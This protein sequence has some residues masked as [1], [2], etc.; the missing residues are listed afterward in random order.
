MAAN[1]F[2]V[3]SLTKCIQV[4]IDLC[5]DRSDF[6]AIALFPEDVQSEA[7]RMVF[8]PSVSVI[9]ADLTDISSN[10]IEEVINS[11]TGEETEIIRARIERIDFLQQRVK[12]WLDFLKVLRKPLP[13]KTSPDD[14]SLMLGLKE[15]V[16]Q[17]EGCFYLDNGQITALTM[18]KNQSLEGEIKLKV[19]EVDNTKKNEL[20]FPVDFNPE[21]RSQNIL[22]LIHLTEGRLS[23]GRD[24]F[25]FFARRNNLSFHFDSNH[26]ILGLPDHIIETD[27]LTILEDEVLA[28]LIQLADP[29]H[30]AKNNLS[31]ASGL[32]EENDR[33]SALE[34]IEI[35]AETLKYC[36]EY[37][38]FLSPPVIRKINL[39]DMLQNILNRMKNQYGLDVKLSI[40]DISE[41]IM[42]AP[43]MIYTLMINLV[44]NAME[45]SKKENSEL[46]VKLDTPEREM[47]ECMNACLDEPYWHFSVANSYNVDN[48]GK[49]KEENEKDYSGRGWGLYISR[50][51]VKVHK[52]IIE[53]QN[54]DNKH[55]VDIIIPVKPDIPNIRKENVP[56]SLML[57]T[58]KNIM[59]AVY[60]GK[61]LSVTEAAGLLSRIQP[62]KW[63]FRSFRLRLQGVEYI[64]S[65][66]I[67]ALVTL[68]KKSREYN[69]DFAISGLDDRLRVILESCHLHELLK[70]CESV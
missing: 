39:K 25:S 32:L 18:L 15:P 29:L 26:V 62:L 33:A 38:N 58:E 37:L 51:I 50:R 41:D 42:A 63:R 40:S 30:E 45:A 66:G 68:Y 14:L 6:Q 56:L 7:V 17:S 23:A 49:A 55:I 10:C 1:F 22:D 12:K 3:D 48:S 57:D 9:F 61:E 53:V 54:N 27:R 13:Q 21:N 31:F 34:E 44:R 70:H 46:I 69:V 67:G 19:I 52:G 16:F 65:A 11:D 5:R 36:S 8:F 35:C 47:L 43:E 24:L 20:L 28:D 60:H 64:D 2:S 59:D 4:Y